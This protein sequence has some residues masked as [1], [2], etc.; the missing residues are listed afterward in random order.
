MSAQLP[1]V[2]SLEQRQPPLDSSLHTLDPL[3]KSLLRDLLPGVTHQKKPKSN[4]EK[5]GRKKWSGAEAPEFLS[6]A[7]HTSPGSCKAS[8]EKAFSQSCVVP[9]PPRLESQDALLLV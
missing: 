6:S 7:G 4:E 9:G 1:A 5:G 3:N 2:C 8:A